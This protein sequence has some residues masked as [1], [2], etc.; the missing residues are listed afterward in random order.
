MQSPR[1]GESPPELEISDERFNTLLNHGIEYA[2]KCIEKRDQKDM[3]PTLGVHIIV[4]DDETYTA[5]LRVDMLLM[6]DFDADHP[7]QYL[8]KLGAAYGKKGAV[9]Q[10]AFLTTEAW[11]SVRKDGDTKG[12][13]ADDPARKEALFV[14]GMTIDKRQNA[15]RVFV[16][17]NAKNMMV[18]GK[19]ES[20]PYV[21]DGKKRHMLSNPH[22]DA[23]FR[24]YMYAYMA[25]LGPEFLAQP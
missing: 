2:Y 16:T 13:P 19:I 3:I 4:P 23:F 25:T 7:S 20:F 10:C 17:R 15:G 12:R 18:P 11:V 14:A 1:A 8:G 22:L 24:G 6:A 9:L 5:S 21:A